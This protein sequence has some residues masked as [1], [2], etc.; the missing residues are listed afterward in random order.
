VSARFS[1]TYT[2]SS[3][4]HT[5]RAAGGY[6]TKIQISGRNSRDLVELLGGGGGNGGANGGGRE[7]AKG[8][9]VGI[10]T[11]VDDKEAKQGRVRVKFPELSD[12]EEGWWARIATM[13][14]GKERGI[15]FRPEVDDEVVV[16]F[17]HGDIT[18]PYVLGSVFNGVDVPGSKLYAGD[19][20]K[21]HDG[22]LLIESHKKFVMNS[23]D[24]IEITTGKTH[25]FKSAEDSAYDVGKNL[26]MKVGG[27][28]IM[29]TSKTITIETGRMQKVVIKAGGDLELQAATPTGKVKITGGQVDI[30]GQMG[31]NVK[32]MSINLG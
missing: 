5:Y 7:W 26:D 24:K 9:V 25:S 20:N 28:W 19:K 15:F 16:G 23:K 3:T 6:R 8:L 10:V 18:R 17:E 12:Q 14:A 30:S 2:L 27:D 11:N 32:G 4:T 21:E 29:K 22:S 13:N 31:V 1:G